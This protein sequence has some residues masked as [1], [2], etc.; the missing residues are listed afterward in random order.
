LAKLTR[1][2]LR[3]G[4]AVLA[5]AISIA[6]LALP[7]IGKGSGAI[8]YLAVVVA[9]WYGGLGPGLLSTAL[10][11]VFAIAVTVIGPD[12]SPSRIAGIVFF[13][14]GG[15][16]AALL[17]EALHASRRRV[18]ISEQWLTAVLNSIG[19]AVIATDAQGRVTFL[20]P[21]ARTLTGWEPEEAA[22]KS[23]TKVFQTIS[24]D[25]R[26]PALDPVARVLREDVV[27]GLSKHTIL[28]AKDGT[29]RPIDD[30]GAPIKEKG[31]ATTGVVL[32]FRDIAERQRLE[33]ELR[34]RLAELAEADRRKDEFL[35]MLAH[36][37]RNPLA[38]ISTAVQL[39]AL[40][41]AADQID[42]SMAVINRQVKHLS[43]LIDDLFDVSRITRGKIRLRKEL[44]D[45]AVIIKLA[46]VSTR[47]LI[48][49]RQ[50]KLTI[51]IPSKA[52]AAEADPL[53]L[54]QIVSNLLTNAAKYTES[55]GQIWLSAEQEGDE[56]VIKVRD[57]GTG[58]P[59]EELSRMFE[60]FAQGD[61]SLAR[62]E[63]GL[64]IGLT[65]AR[66][67][68]EL[69][70]GSLTG[71]SAGSGRGSEFVVRL[72]AASPSSVKNVK[73]HPPFELRSR[74][75]S[76]VLVIED[77]LDV[78]RTLAKLLK[79]LNYEV[80]TAYD[81][82]T[83]LAAARDHRPQVVL[84]DIG[85]PGLNGYQVAQQLRQEEFGKD[86]FLVAVSGYG[87][88]EYRRQARCAGFD[89]FVTKPVDFK[90]LRTL[91]VDPGER[92]IETPT[93]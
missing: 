59:P 3:Y 47:P 77:N 1:L 26:Q 4:V 73:P 51:S 50:H 58:I 18:E 78:A 32:V 49:A 37:L 69:H 42:W 76:R 43:L 91:L 60:L 81:A 39:S 44:L 33:H 31:G 41:K 66:S 8:L 40:S 71:T 9:A 80:W 89:H 56:I 90:T 6:F 74:P 36:E 7:E 24:E 25:S 34:R 88:E 29:E 35:A 52:L 22:G 48:E 75:G 57:T 2:A 27:V 12:K 64:G 70:G 86:V 53:R 28:I 10:I 46:V 15:V 82:Q 45:V 65:L 72:P 5:V 84:L 54:E 16:L 11:A 30:S 87:Q 20:N 79:L 61:R 68:A 19:D 93:L 62:S 23:L 13:V 17:V 63:G 14:G 92:S 83:G 85:L 21:V 55:G 67:L 38:A